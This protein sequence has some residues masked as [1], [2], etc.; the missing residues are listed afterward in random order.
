MIE[1]LVKVCDDPCS[2][3][4][5]N[6]SASDNALSSLLKCVM[7]KTQTALLTKILPLMPCKTDILEA[8]V[9]HYH[10]YKML[11]SNKPE[12]AQFQPAIRDTLLKASQMREGWDE[13]E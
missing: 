3:E 12:W 7:Y 4:G 13:S 5:N 8:R 6:A 11:A 1:A 10:L 2:R 9:I